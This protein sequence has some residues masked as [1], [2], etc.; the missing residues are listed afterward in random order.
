MPESS[1]LSKRKE[2][3][4]RG[5][6]RKSGRDR[7]RRFLAEGLRVVDEALS[8]R[9]RV[10]ELVGTPSTAPDIELWRA[11]G[12]LEGI[13]V[14]LTDERTFRRLAESIHPQGVLAVVEEPEVDL[15][16]VS[17]RGP[18]L[19][20]DRLQDPGNAGTLLRSLQ[21]VGGR[22]LL[23][24]TGTVDLFNPKVVRA[25][26]GSLFHLEVA[27]R[28]RAAAALEWAQ[29]R[30]LPVFALDQRGEPLFGPGWS[31]PRS[32]VLAVG[33]E[34]GGLAAEILER[35]ERRLA[36]P[37]ARG[38]DSLNAAVAGSVALYEL[39]RRQ[40]GLDPAPPLS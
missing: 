12:K 9:L 33:N 7:R 3:F 5:L 13:G 15:K 38:V 21:A 36:L 35:S 4:L 31:A 32:F 27:V 22:T 24:L 16:R 19:L 2:A 17:S 10:T 30:G 11:A 29:S 25:S 40:V 1:R 18:V 39:C 6:A 8:G 34:G 28:L 20:L 26:A 37:M 23:A 14:S